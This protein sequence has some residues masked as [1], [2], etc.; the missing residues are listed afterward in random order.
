MAKRRL[1]TQLPAF[2]QTQELTKFF[3]STVDEVFQPGTSQPISGYIG[4]RPSIDANDFYVGEPT[5]SR[6]AYQLESGMVSYDTTG[7]LVE[8]LSYPDFVGYLQT[9]G[10]NVTDQQRLFDTEYYSWAPPINIDMLV[11]YRNYYWFGDANGATDLPALVLTVPMTMATGDG[12]TTTF[13]L[14]S[15]ILAVPSID[16]AP[17]V[18]VNY[19]PVS[20]FVSGNTVVLGSAPP[21]GAT[22]LVARTFSLID[23]I[24]GLTTVNVSD[25]NSDGVTYLTSSMRIKVIDAAYTIG[26]WDAPPWDDDAWDLSGNGI[27]MVD[28]VGLSMRFTPDGD[29]LRGLEAQYVTIDRSSLDANLWSLHNSWV[30]KDSF[31]WADTTALLQVT[32]A[33]VTGSISGATLSVTAVL[34]GSLAVGQTIAGAGITP[35]TTIVAFGSGSGSVGTYLLNSAQTVSTTTISATII[36]PLSARQAT[37]PIVEF[38]RDIVL[39]SDSAVLASNATIGATSLTFTRSLPNLTG[40]LVTG[41][42]VPSHTFVQSVQGT[43]IT[44]SEAITGAMAADATISFSQPWSESTDPLFML[45]D[46]N[47]IALNNPTTYPGSTFIG[48]RIFGY[49]TGTTFD[50]VLVRFVAFDSNDYYIF[51]NDT[52][53]NPASFTGGPI[54]SLYAYATTDMTT[55]YQ[56]LW[57]ESPV[58]T[59]Q[60]TTNGFFDVPLNLQAN[61]SSEDVNTISRS[62]WIDHFSSIIANQPELVGNAL[63]DNN[64]R[65]TTRDLTVGTGILQHRCPLLKAMLLASD[66]TYDLPQA[67]RYADQEYNRFRNK[68]ARRL[69]DLRNRG[70]LLDSDAPTT[71]VTTA[72]NAIKIG[73]TNQFPFALNTIG[74]GQYFIP[75]TPTCLGVLPAAVPAMVTDTTYATSVLMILGHDGSLT[76]AFNDWRDPIILTLEQ[77]I[78]ANLPSQ[79]RT[80]ARPGFDIQQWIG[81]RFF[82]PFDGYTRDEVTTIL[83][84][85]FELWAQA[86]FFDYR[87]NVNYDVTNPFTWNFR[88]VPDY[89]G[90]PLPG[91]WRAIYH[92]Y[93]GTDAP[94][95]RPWEMLGFQYEPTWWVGAYGAAPYT[96]SNSMWTD[97]EN[98][99]IVGGPRAGTD[100]DYSRPG[101]SNIIP[102]D[103]AGNLLDPIAVG[104]VLTNVISSVASRSWLPGDQGPVETLWQNSPSYRFALAFAAFMMKPVRLVEECWDTLNIGFV[105]SQWVNLTTLARPVNAGLYAHGE[106][107]PAGATVVVTGISQWIAD[108]LLSTNHTSATFGTGVRGLDVRLIHQMAGF[109]ASEDMKVV[110]ESF[111]LLPSEDITTFL[112]TSPMTSTQVYS[113]VIL[114][115]TGR[116]WRAI[117]Y[118][119]RNPNFTTIPPD[120]NGPK[121]LISIATSAEPSIVEWRPN[122]YFPAGI[123]AEHANSVWQ[124]TRGNTS[125]PQF[126]QFYWTP[127]PDLST[128]MIRAPRVVTYVRGLHTTVQVPYGVEFFTYQQVADFLLGYERWLVAQGWSFTNM[129]DGGMILNWSMAVREFLTWAQVQWAPGN[130]IALSPGQQGLDFTTD[131]GTILNVESPTDGFFGLLDRSGR[132]IGSRDSIISRLDGDI[133]MYAKEADIFCARLGFAD[134]E[135][136]LVFSNVTIF[137]DNIYLPLF[138]MRQTRLQLICKRSTD[139]AGRLDAPGFMVI[140]NQLKSDFEKATDD[141]RLMFDIELTDRVDLYDYARHVIGFQ[142]RD[143]LE[144][145]LLADVEQFEFYQGMIQ[146]KGAPGVFQKLTRSSRA[147]NNS[148]LQFLE[149]WGI[150][151]S[152]FGAPIDPL[153]IFQFGQTDTRD[154][155]QLIRL[156]PTTGAPLDWIVFAN[157]DS[158]WID[159]PPAPG[160]FFTM[161]TSYARAAVPTAGPL[162]VT[163]VSE[164]AFNFADVPAIYTTLQQSGI[165]PFPTGSSTW[166][167]Q[168]AED[169][170]YTVLRSFETGSVPNQLLT[171]VSNA[172]DD[173]VTTTRLFFQHTFTLTTADVG[174]YLVIDG[175]S[176]SAPEL[177]GLQTILDVNVGS[178][179]V[180]LVTVSTSGFDYTMTE[181]DAPFIRVLREVRFVTL[182]ALLS[183]GYVFAVNDMAWI[184][185]YLSSG[186]WSVVQWSGS[187]W[188]VIR[189]QPL[190]ADPTTISETLIY[191]AGTTLTDQ[192]MITDE[193]IVAAVDVID[194]LSNLLPGIAEREIDFR[195]EY[196]PAGYNAGNS[197]VAVNPWG[198]RQVGRVWW[199]LAT[200]KFLDPYTDTL[201]VS[202]DRDLAEL[203]YRTNNWTHIAP[204]ASVDIYEWTMSTSD[205]TAYTGPGTV[206]NATLPSWS[207]QTTFDTT[208]NAYVTLYFFWVSGLT[209]TPTVPFRHTDISTVALAITNPSGLDLSWMAPISEDAMIVSG[210]VQFL[211]D[212]TTAMRVQLT[213][214]PDNAGRHD[215]WV[216]MRPEDDTSLPPPYVWQKLCDSLAGF[217]PLL[218]PI[219]DPR[220]NT[221][222]ATGIRPGQSMFTVAGPSGPRAGL[223]AARQSFVGI[224]N[225]IFARTP[226]MRDLLAFTHTLFRSTPL[227]QYLLWAQLDPSYIYEPPPRNEWDIEVFG[228]DERNKLLARS[229]FLAALSPSSLTP[230]RVLLNGFSNPLQQWSIWEFDPVAANALIAANPSIPVDQLLV[231]NADTVFNL[232]LAYDYQVTSLAGRDALTVAGYGID[233]F[234]SGPYGTAIPPIVGTTLEAGDRVLVTG[235]FWSIWMF[236]PGDPAADSAGFI[237]W[238]VQTYRTDDFV[239]QVDWY[240]AGYAASNPPV[241]SYAT[242]TQRNT[243]EGASPTNQ[244]VNI[245]DDGTGHWIWTQYNTVSNQWDTVAI[246]SGTLALSSNF[247]D[248]SRAVHGVEVWQTTNAVIP[249]GST[250]LSLL[251][252]TGIN[253][254]Q[255]VM[256][257]DAFDRFTKVAAVTATSVTVD[258]PTLV[259]IANNVNIGFTT[260]SL[261]D[262]SNRDGSWEIDV[263]AQSLRYGG[264]LM[265]ADVNE[266]FFSILNFVHVQQDSVDWA[267]KTSFMSIVGYNVPLEQTP[268]LLSDQTDSLLNYIN[269]VK[270]YRVKI[271]SFSTQYNTD[272]DIATTTVTEDNAFDITLLFNRYTFEGWDLLEWDSFGWDDNDSAI[273]LWDEELWDTDPW[274]S[275]SN[276]G[277]VYVHTVVTATLIA[278]SPI[279]E[280]DDIRFIQSTYLDDVKTPVSANNQ[281]TI[282]IGSNAYQIASVVPDAVNVSTVVDGA[283]KRVGVSGLLTT[284]SGNITVSD[285]TAG[286]VVEAILPMPDAARRIDDYYVPT[287]GMPPVDLTVLLD[288]GIDPVFVTYNLSADALSGVTVLSLTNTTNI[289]VNQ[290]VFGP[291][292]VRGTVVTAL[293]S[294]TITISVAI[295]GTIVAGTAITIALPTNI[296]GTDLVPSTPPD[297]YD[298][299]SGWTSSDVISLN[300]P[301]P[302]RPGGFDLREPYANA[303]PEERVPFQSNDSLHLMVTALPEA[304]AP[305]EITRMFNVTGLSGTV[306]LFFGMVAQSSTAVLVYRDG[307]RAT[308]GTDYTVSYFDCT[309]TVNVSS[310]Q[311]VL[312]HAF[313]FGGASTIIDTLYLSYAS[314]PLTIDTTTTAA[315]NVVVNGTLLTSGYSVSGDQ[316]TLSSPPSVGAD[317]AV[318]IFAGSATAAAQ[319]S[320]QTFTYSSGPQTFTLNPFDSETTPEV[321]GTIVEVNGL[322]LTPTVAYTVSGATLTISA[323]LS[324]GNTV[325]VTLFSNAATMGIQTVAYPVSGSGPYLVPPP[326]DKNYIL[327]WMDGLLLTPDYDYDFSTTS[328]FGVGAY[329][330]G[331][332]GFLAGSVYLNIFTPTS[333]YVVA[334][335]FTDAPASGLIQWMENSRLPATDRMPPVLDN[336]GNPVLEI[337]AHGPAI[338]QPVF[339][340]LDEY[341]AVS[342]L[343]AGTL[344]SVLNPDDVTITIDLFLITVSPKLLPGQPLTI[345]GEEPGSIWIGSERIEYFNLS[346]S[347]NVVTLSQLRRGTRGTSIA[348]QRQVM[349]L[350]ATGSPQ[351]HV[352]TGTGTVEVTI[353]G[354][355]TADFTSTVVGGNQ[356]VVFTATLGAFVVIALT[357]GYVYPVGAIVYNG[358]A[359]FSPPVPLE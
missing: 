169:N 82:E 209:V 339:R 322:R 310:N 139:W 23:E 112:Y 292:I 196:D 246:Q 4:R 174:N 62:T 187:A 1:I 289:V 18:Y 170:T 185:N 321:G 223:L 104:I 70:V 180:D 54:T 332:Y 181:S 351:G 222:R 261:N 101:L 319:I 135:H 20:F 237:L 75:P 290:A 80:E 244:F 25:I 329:G 199:N 172:E 91:N 164:T 331:L 296:A 250:T 96:S 44:L 12:V 228:L 100:D 188:N 205:P 213:L 272:V 299:G 215:E 153:L 232:A 114:E 227:S 285:G 260:L 36:T 236:Q 211:N 265:D 138:N 203:A 166:V 326:W 268:V 50:P 125:G 263:L 176:Q 219:P 295:V 109:T 15:S 349:T 336:S 6:A 32:R 117:G 200:V 120:P 273:D 350:T 179:Y 66:T 102:V 2:Q 149:E 251:L 197:D 198:L 358:D 354:V 58:A 52:V 338:A 343:T 107:N 5:A 318:A 248:P 341:L 208:L 13:D 122:V 282:R 231:S 212:T 161:L 276:T 35:G 72:L 98:G 24:S 216:L 89:A 148:D 64:Y 297:E 300:P 309:V 306:T 347:S 81:G 40:R 333:G 239:S 352:F 155:P 191:S 186:Q 119:A 335:V 311:R 252:T 266:T 182:S 307:V 26:A 61:P 264:M 124:C 103:Q 105:G 334:T 51:D 254:G 92:Y 207:T 214:D 49:T 154:D 357:T 136:A 108:Y 45:Y 159:P 79:F 152:E 287:T 192:Q 69:V 146:Q 28:G 106:I 313:G 308:L 225:T 37:R 41:S 134:I 315:I 30:H 162:R 78:Y 167:Y 42:G 145:L 240:A 316:L 85:M 303:Q 38:V 278:D 274:D 160:S 65:D 129:A 14:P 202:E 293:T 330:D 235:D 257:G 275:S 121:G 175:L 7:T 163:D 68:F 314:N 90:N 73:K 279:I 57:H 171:T 288:L 31:A 304:G 157:D 238:R 210:V 204:N 74:G 3:G 190:R 281:L 126:E 255:F 328:G 141:V 294:T 150:R 34:S 327:V 270:P 143:Y 63:G 324:A 242:V 86:N 116:S 17:V 224:I 60:G 323:S 88:G 245:V 184:D 189:T 151:L 283:S 320:V 353:N 84:P 142:T 71:W 230:I 8:A 115:W 348:E 269:E 344:A 302:S 94:H 87:T 221:L 286:N 147:S 301:L 226:A 217:D 140:G 132:P 83:V 158:R 243:T 337:P 123:L 19:L 194:P 144:N 33:V 229:D 249:A 76:P 262:V 183:S 130:F 53:T 9:S 133:T 253:V 177:Q 298:G 131:T 256:A 201:G 59:T 113:G 220:I 277:Y 127:R 280:V 193:P 11:N 110:A 27:Y 10:A 43:T 259:G 345:P 325:T 359:Y 317:V 195:S 56:A 137:D 21:N 55:T 258:T 77:T 22:V 48:N 46:L 165:T 16:E 156:I 67:I 346:R 234:G 312:V 111:G 284:V 218:N 97:L 291:N 206:Y 356:Q 355:P 95:T 29:I 173:T 168:R 39:W 271:R 233:P 340:L 305:P 93:Y 178:Q 118:D 128:A 47:Q 342:P 241:V 267:F 99:T 247:Y